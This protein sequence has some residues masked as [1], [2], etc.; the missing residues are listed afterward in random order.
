MIEDITNQVMNMLREATLPSPDPL[1][2]RLDAARKW[3]TISGYYKHPSQLESLRKTLDIIDESV[4]QSRSLEKLYQL[5]SEDRHK[6]E[7]PAIASDAAALAIEHGD[8]REA[9]TL[10]ER[11][12]AIIF[13]RL[14]HY[15]QGF[16]DV[17]AKAPEL[18]LCLKEL[19]AE[20]EGLVVKQGTAVAVDCAAVGGLKALG[21]R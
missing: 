14:G 7:V 16:D 1:S 4:A 21:T 13:T 10:L 19:S 15:R 3:R 8:I 6:Q 12:R 17:D 18:A 11:G 9:V 2:D 20:L 5:L